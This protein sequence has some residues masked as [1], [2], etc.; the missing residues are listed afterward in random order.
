MTRTLSPTAGSVAPIQ[1]PTR[2]SRRGAVEIPA[3]VEAL[4]ET[5]VDTPTVVFRLLLLARDEVTGEEL[6]VGSFLK[7][8]SMPQDLIRPGIDIALELFGE[9]RVFKPAAIIW[10]EPNQ[11]CVVEV[12][13]MIADRPSIVDK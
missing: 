11:V 6:L 13:W 4:G 2:P 10:D 9:R 5:V 1:M 12:E 7:Q 8:V 3:V